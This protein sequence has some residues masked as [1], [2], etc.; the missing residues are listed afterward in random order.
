VLIRRALRPQD[1]PSGKLTTGPG[2]EQQLQM[3]FSTG[4]QRVNGYVVALFFP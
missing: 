4:T 2:G 1:F 3:V